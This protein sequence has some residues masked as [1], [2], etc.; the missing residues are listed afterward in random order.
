MS[1]LVVW[2]SWSMV[3]ALG[4]L[5]AWRGVPSRGV[6]ATGLGTAR[7]RGAWL[8]AIHSPVVPRTRSPGGARARDPDERPTRPRFSEAGGRSVS[9]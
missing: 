2:L 9:G 8:P 4:L 6:I 5:A 7:L 1:A 3:F